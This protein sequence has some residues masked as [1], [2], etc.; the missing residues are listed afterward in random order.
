MPTPTKPTPGALAA[1]MLDDGIKHM[2][3]NPKGVGGAAAKKSITAAV[4]QMFQDELSAMPNSPCVDLTVLL[5]PTQSTKPEDYQIATLTFTPE[6]DVREVG[7]MPHDVGQTF[8]QLVGAFSKPLDD[9][10]K[11]GEPVIVVPPTTPK[12]GF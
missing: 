10:M 2:L 1:E 8:V 12:C 6:G 11:K 4:N 5:N 3:K 9:Q 7:L